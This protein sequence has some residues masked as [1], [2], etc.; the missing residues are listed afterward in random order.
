MS[1]N[2]GTGGTGTSQA[3]FESSDRSQEQELIL[4]EQTQTQQQ[5]QTGLVGTVPVG[6]SIPEFDGLITEISEAELVYGV[7]VIRPDLLANFDLS[8]FS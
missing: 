4:Q 6:I 7:N 3:P 1:I 2:Y 8:R 5:A